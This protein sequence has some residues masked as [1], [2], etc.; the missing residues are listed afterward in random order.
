VASELANGPIKFVFGDYVKGKAEAEA[1]VT[2]DF[3]T[4][5][6]PS[7]QAHALCMHCRTASQA[8]SASLTYQLTNLLTHRRGGARPEAGHHRRRPSR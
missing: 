4:T 5:S 2:N 3:G 1:A 7:A 6:T 8:S